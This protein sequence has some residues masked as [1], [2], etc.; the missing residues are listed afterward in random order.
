MYSMLTLSTEDHFDHQIKLF[1]QNNRSMNSGQSNNQPY[2]WLTILSDTLGTR[3][4]ALPVSLVEGNDIPLGVLYCIPDEIRHMTRGTLVS[5]AQIQD[6]AEH[7]Y[8]LAVNLFGDGKYR[9]VSGRPFNNGC[10]S[11]NTVL[12][13]HDGDQCTKSDC[14]YY[15]SSQYPSSTFRSAT[16][17]APALNRTTFRYDFK[18]LETNPR[19]FCWIQNNIVNMMLLDL[20]D[21]L[22][23]NDPDRNVIR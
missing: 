19:A 14:K 18:V 20:F 11:V 8:V 5:Q 4:L 10:A 12:P 15:H 1:A 13:C 6:M 3:H 17:S 9:T 16:F 21:S 23:S 2:I 22:Y 7:D